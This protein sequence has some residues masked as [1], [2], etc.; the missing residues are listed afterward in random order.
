MKLSPALKGLLIASLACIASF[1]I[2]F[3]WLAKKD[4]Y[5]VDNPTTNTY[6]FTINDG[7]EKIIGSGQFVE[8]PLKKGQKNTF[9]VWD[10]NKKPLYD[11]IFEVSKDRGLLNIARKDYYINTQYYGYDLNRD[12]L[13]LTFPTV[14]IDG[15]VYTGDV[16]KMNSIYNEDFYFNVNENYDAVVK[17]VQKVESRAKIFRKD[18]FLNYYQEYYLKK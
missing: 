16:R 13:L 15:K 4:H 17:N 1:A 5:L 6:Y 14:L 9:K 10:A 12:S 8:V 3:F 18:D 2:Y 11:T 7:G